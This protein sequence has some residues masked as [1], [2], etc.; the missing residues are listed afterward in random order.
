MGEQP[1][2]LD[3]QEMAAWLALLGVVQRLPQALDRQ[4]R[5]EA[6]LHH[7]YYTALALLSAQPD[8]RLTLRELARQAAMSQSRL[9]HAVSSMEERG[10]LAR[11]PCPTDKRVQFAELTDAGRALLREVA[12]GHVAE[13]RRRVFDRLDP[14]DVAHLQRIAGALL[15]GLE[16]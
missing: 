14:D 6:G 2:W 8:G 11:V 5:D 3:E 10:L 13:V 16:P 15:S 9:T 4:L 12:P 1:R 7:V